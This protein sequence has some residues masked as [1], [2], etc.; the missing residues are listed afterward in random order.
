MACIEW[1]LCIPLRGNIALLH[2][3]EK[4]HSMVAWAYYVN[5]PIMLYSI[6]QRE[7]RWGRG[8]EVAMFW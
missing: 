3:T 4:Q 6:L 8:G 2:C 7:K 5:G 1:F